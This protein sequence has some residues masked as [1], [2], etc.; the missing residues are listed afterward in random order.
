M[1]QTVIVPSVWNEP[2]PYVVAEALTRKRLVIASRIGGI[3]ELLEGCKG[4]VECEPGNVFQLADA[5]RNVQ[6]MA[7]E[8]RLELGSKNSEVFRKRF[9][10]EDSVESFIN[11]ASKIM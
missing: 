5:I 9:K 4:V 1:V 7:N 11:L 6:E 10:D 3:P 8:E 2:L